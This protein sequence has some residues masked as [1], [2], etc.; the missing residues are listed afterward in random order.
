MTRAA[1]FAGL[2][3][4]VASRTVQ[5]VFAAL[6]SIAGFV[7][8]HRM[9]AETSWAAVKSQIS[10]MPP[11]LVALSA[12]GTAIS[13]AAAG[14]YDV[15][16]LRA[17]AP[18][19]I[20]PPAAAATG[21]AGFAVSNV[22]G[23]GVVTGAAMRMRVY[24]AMGLPFALAAQVVAMANLWVLAGLLSLLACALL[25]HPAGLATLLPL[26][27]PVEIAIGVAI[28][29][30]LVLAGWR[31]TRRRKAIVL[32]GHAIPLPHA[33][34]L[35]G[36]ILAG[37]FDVGGAALA[38]WAL[39]PGDLGV[40][41]PAFLAIYL[42]AILLGVA[43]M[44]PG[45]IG[46][47]EAS[48]IAGLG[49][50]G[51]ADVLA[52]L[53]LYRLIYY[54]AP[55]L[56]ALV[57]GAVVGAGHA[58][59]RRAVGAIRA[60]MRP[61]VPPLAAGL[62]LLAGLVLLV[63]GGLPAEGA[64][65]AVLRDVLPLAL[66]EGSHLAGSVVGVL[67]LVMARGLYLRRARAWTTTM[68]LLLVGL[69]ASTFKGLDWEEV[70]IS[71]LALAAMWAFRDAFYRR[72]ASLFRLPWQWLMAS[73]VLVGLSIWV[74][75]AAYRD[76]PYDADLWW[77]FAWSGDAPRFLRASLAAAVAFGAVAL[78]SLVA[79]SG[80]RLPPEPVPDAVR[81]IA[82]A[83]DDT[84]G[85]IA[86]TGGKRYLVS[87]E[88]TA[89]LSYADSGRTLITKGDPVGDHT[90]GIALLWQLREIAD[91]MG[92]RAAY[93]AVWSAYLP[94]YLD[95]GLSILKIGEVAR[96]DL[97]AFDLAGGHRKGLR[98]ARSRA[99]REGV[100][101]E[102]VPAAEIAGL[103]PEL[104]KISDEWLSLK[105][106]EEKAFA[107]GSFNEAYL[108]NFDHALLR[109]GAGGPVLAFAN[110][111]KGGEGGELS[112]DLMRHG[113]DAP[114]YAMDVLFVEMFLWGK[115]KGF[116]W[117]PL[118][119]APL[120]GLERHRLAGLWNRVGRFAYDHGERFYH[121]E[122]L[123]G[124]KEKFD[125]VWSPN[126][127]ASPHGLDAARTLL[128]VNALISGGVRGILK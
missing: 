110:L 26:T 36:G 118:G 112:I 78:N 29:G 106:G 105:Q 56:L 80:D 77:R 115:A 4:I 31:I 95:M 91:R 83:S 66:I 34:Y 27:A 57:A 5:I 107:L 85:Q 81:L 67:L 3:R 41:L 126:Y 55:F 64:R 12:L 119:A 92:R 98:T 94:T 53:A 25:L 16:G 102:V 101:F 9:A 72:G 86:L 33:R 88:S 24:T 116:R 19:R 75:L 43:S 123:R 28:L 99:A 104:R 7:I 73:A 44:A 52:A 18:G 1:A 23:F 89:F 15:I 20:A 49:A 82:L 48:L 51:R 121:F 124:F 76:V 39:L 70:L 103:L 108:K 65:L 47:F 84:E 69:G 122:G 125:P 6:I 54:V 22:L 13:L 30:G 62:T 68:A 127:L 40:S 97:Q 120:A 128:E 17:I 10:A 8:L 14:A 45:G 42:V 37:M 58:G 60:V 71:A 114:G 2:R 79:G 59:S 35:L 93:Y 11:A 61:I 32:G 38:L 100:V 109:R 87:P 96:V 111:M 50:S 90:A 113:T 117:F 63:S 21:A 46:V 74:G